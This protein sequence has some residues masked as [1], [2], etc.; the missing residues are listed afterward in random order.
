MVAIDVE[1]GAEIESGQ[2]GNF[3]RK[4][5]DF[6]GRRQTILEADD[7]LIGAVADIAVAPLDRQENRLA[8]EVGLHIRGYLYAKIIGHHQLD[9]DLAGFF[10]IADLVLYARDE[11]A[12]DIVTERQHIA[13]VGFEQA[14]AP[15]PSV[16]RRFYF[17]VLDI[18]DEDPFAEQQRAASIVFGRIVAEADDD[19]ADVLRVQ[20]PAEDALEGILFDAQAAV[21]VVGIDVC[22]SE[23]GEIA[24]LGDSAQAIQ[25]GED[26]LS[27]FGDFA[28]EAL[29][30]RIVDARSN[31]GQGV[32]VG[33]HIPLDAVEE[34]LREGHRRKRGPQL[35]AHGQCS[36]ELSFGSRGYQDAV[37]PTIEAGILE[38]AAAKIERV[39]LTPVVDAPTTSDVVAVQIVIAISF[40]EEIDVALVVVPG[41]VGVLVGLPAIE[42]KQR[43]GHVPFPHNRTQRLKIDGRSRRSVRIEEPALQVGLEFQWQEGEQDKGPNGFIHRASFPSR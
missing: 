17:R 18:V 37:E 3:K 26:R 22:Q 40:Q 35:F 13:A 34:R 31:E 41:V 28:V 43:L 7:L 39:F 25:I 24:D 27:R 42:V 20:A 10:E 36:V 21:P 1:F 32:F 2:L 15:R 8:R 16:N 29:D 12:F 6:V 9:I 4:T 38:N 5:H 14:L 23:C 30:S 11:I 33:L 19:A